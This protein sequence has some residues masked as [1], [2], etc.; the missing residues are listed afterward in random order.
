MRSNRRNERSCL[1]QTLGAAVSGIG[2]PIAIIG[3]GV[4][5]ALKFIRKDKGNT[6]FIDANNIV[7]KMRDQ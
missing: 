5:A 2:M 3:V 7:E 4:A 6:I 1:H